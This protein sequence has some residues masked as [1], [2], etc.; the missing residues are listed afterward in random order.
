M[1]A[2]QKEDLAEG[3]LRNREVT[4]EGSPWQNA[5]L[6]NKNRTGEHTG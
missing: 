1:V 6:M 5:G 4:W 3:Q 2:L